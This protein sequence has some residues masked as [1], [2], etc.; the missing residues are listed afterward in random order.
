MIAESSESQFV[1]LAFKDYIMESIESF[2]SI[3]DTEVKYRSLERKFEDDIYTIKQAY[4]MRSTESEGAEI[5]VKFG[6]KIKAF[7]IKAWEFIVSIFERICEII[8][9]L[10]KALIIFVQKKRIQMTSVFQLFEKHGGIIGYNNTHNNI[11]ERALNEKLGVKTLVAPGKHAT[12]SDIFAL[13]NSQGLKSFVNAKV[14]VNNT[15]SVFS[16]AAL[17]KY[18]GIM[19]KLGET[20]KIRIMEESV[21][22]LYKNGIFFNEVDVGN[23][24]D[25][26][27]L[28]K[29]I[30]SEPKLREAISSG[31]VD[32]VA[33][34]IVTGTTT[35]TYDELTLS[36][37]FNLRNSG[38]ID[39]KLLQR[40]FVEYYEL[41]KKVVNPGGYIDSLESVI[42]QYSRKAHEDRKNIAALKKEVIEQIK[43]Y[44]DDETPE[45]KYKLDL[46][47]R[48]TRVVNKVKNVKL[49]FIRLRQTAIIDIM[50]LYSIE[51]T[52]WYYATGKFAS[53]KEGYYGDPEKDDDTLEI[54]KHNI[55]V[56]PD[57]EAVFA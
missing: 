1:S 31:K 56:R 47:H 10:V 16:T 32:D 27:V 9:Q 7:F 17:T 55:I 12:H 38:K 50:R 46:Y 11:I 57:E 41:S 35:P 25:L 30:T 42:K 54:S 15:A 48:F 49:H 4:K 19:T 53:L 24:G 23:T 28:Q 52:A 8:V 3:C 29:M 20:D 13:L 22:E 5:K 26:G 36:Q 21:N 2:K 51:N 37:Y 39:L 43:K 33:H 44:S 6:S 40:L 14:L 18:V 34:F 45:A